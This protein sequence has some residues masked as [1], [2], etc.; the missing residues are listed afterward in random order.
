M[1]AGDS[2]GTLHTFKCGRPERHF[3]GSSLGLLSSEPG[4]PLGIYVPGAWPFLPLPEFQLLIDS[5]KEVR[6]RG[7]GCFLL[8]S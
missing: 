1:P 2:R 6:S 8:F 4:L 5:M 7:W 3:R